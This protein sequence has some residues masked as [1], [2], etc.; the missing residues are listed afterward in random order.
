MQIAE[1]G[2]AKSYYTMSVITVFAPKKSE[3]F[4]VIVISWHFHVLYGK[5]ELFLDTFSP[6]MLFSYLT[7]CVWWSVS[8]WA[9]TCS[10]I[11]VFIF[12]TFCKVRISIRI[13]LRNIIQ[14]EKRRRRKKKQ[15]KQNKINNNKK[16]KQ[17]KKT[18][19]TK[20]KKKKKKKCILKRSILSENKQ[21]YCLD[22][23]HSF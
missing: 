10:F 13:N 17:K 11:F 1:W 5:W 2:T 15:T 19:T 8:S 18:T 9:P 20:K 12:S 16:K 14:F 23:G 6:T 21:T 7:M 3:F 22:Y 4:R